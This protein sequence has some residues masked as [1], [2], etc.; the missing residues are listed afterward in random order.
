MTR[1]PRASTVVATDPDTAFA[2]FTDE[3]A[4]WWKPSPRRKVGLRGG[5]LFF[6][7]GPKGRLCERV[8]GEV[9]E[10]G[11]VL[12]WEPG[13]R[14]SFAWRAPSFEADESTEVEVRFDR[15]AEGTRVSIEHRGWQAIP[16]ER[17]RA[18][19]DDA[20]FESL[21]GLW[22]GDILTALRHRIST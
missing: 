16:H 15:L 10:V 5:T 21:V 17:L 11:R 4:L 2:L 18:G 19:L 20:S 7:P 9:F 13:E 6:E 14:L 3:I 1:T 8:E 12:V 22:W